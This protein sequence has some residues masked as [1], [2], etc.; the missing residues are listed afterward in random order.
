M[1]DYTT[2]HLSYNQNILKTLLQI[3]HTKLII[4][5]ENPLKKNTVIYLKSI[6]GWLFDL[7][8]YSETELVENSVGTD[9]IDSCDLVDE[10]IFELCPCLRDVN[11]LLSTCRLSQEQRDVGSFRHITPVSLNV[12]PQARIRNKEKELQVLISFFL[13]K[14]P[15]GSTRT[16]LKF[17]FRINFYQNLVIMLTL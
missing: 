13:C 16:Q 4:K 17:D 10:S 1:L 7:P 9:N 2:L 15:T 6:L 3:Y 8:H 5:N 12:D 14:K 11:T